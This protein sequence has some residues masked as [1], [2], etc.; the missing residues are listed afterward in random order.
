MGE[1]YPLEELASLPEFYHPVASPDGEKVAFYWDKSGRN[2]LHVMDLESGEIEQVSDGE[3]PKNARWFI[4]WGSDSE[5]IYFH[6]D[7]A[8]NEQNDIYSIDLEGNVESVVTVDG[9]CIL[10]DMSSDGRF[11]LFTS[12][13]GEQMNLYKYDLQEE[14]MEKLTEYEQPVVNALFSPDD[15]YIAYEANES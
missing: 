7:E 12:D 15:E 5:K 1:E 13:K 8:G 6:K 11:L 9:Q 10:Q 3:V 2:E 4:M 14:S